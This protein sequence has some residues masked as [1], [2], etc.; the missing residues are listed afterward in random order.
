MIRGKPAL[1]EIGKLQT[2]FAISFA[3]FH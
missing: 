3:A 1:S 2:G